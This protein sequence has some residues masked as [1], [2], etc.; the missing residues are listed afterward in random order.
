MVDK[1]LIEYNEQE[2]KGNMVNN[3]VG[4]FWGVI[5]MKFVVF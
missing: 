3:C 5:E 1:E 2:R 4:F